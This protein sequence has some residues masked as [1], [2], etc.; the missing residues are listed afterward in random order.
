[1]GIA[2][3]KKLNANLPDWAK[4]TLAPI[5]RKSLIGNKIYLAQYAELVAAEYENTEVIKKKQFAILKQTLIHAYEHT[6][7]YKKLMD[8]VNFNVYEFDDVDDI[9]KLPVLTKEMIISNFEALQA[10]DVVDF[11]A[12]TTGGSTGN[13]LKVYLDRA[14]IYKE[15]AFIYHFW[16]KYGYDYNCSKVA[17]FRGT[18]FNGKISKANPLYNEIQFNPC[19]INANTIGSYYK[20]M[21]KFGVQFLHGFPSAIYSFCRF[22]KETGLNIKGKYRAVFFISENVYPYQ[23][24][25]I[26][27]ALECPTAAFFGH[28]ER[29]V[30]AEEYNGKYYFN[31]LYGFWEVKEDTGEIICTGFLNPKM[32]FIR[33]MLDDTAM[34]KD[35][36]YEITGHREGLLYG[37]DSELISA[38][39]LEVHSPILDKISNYQFEQ[40]EKGKVIVR[41][42][43][44]CKL[45]TEEIETVRQLFQTKVGKA[46]EVVVECTEK[47][48]YTQRGKFKL[49]IQNVK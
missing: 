2:L 32:P 45:E 36:G 13:P 30:F 31:D 44:F 49:V 29:N 7:Y 23:R 17:S 16:S 38:A 3:L 28:T 24:Q 41:I 33:Y 46:I 39:A 27:D 34:L 6:A 25:F 15:R 12:A 5:I 22:A 4:V 26:E 8:D 9:Q 11:Y 20:K 21:E 43:P 42:I 47:L 18:D 35:E 1:M 14:S 40:N 37:K 19:M 48:K 10:D